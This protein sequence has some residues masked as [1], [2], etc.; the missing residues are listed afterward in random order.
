MPIHTV[1]D[2][3][4]SDFISGWKGCSNIISHHLSFIW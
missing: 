3:H 1:G 4:S 2:S